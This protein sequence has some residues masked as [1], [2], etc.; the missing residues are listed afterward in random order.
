MTIEVNK[1]VKAGL[2]KKVA[3]PDDGRRV[4]LTVTKMAQAKLNALAPTQCPVNDAIFA[5]LDSKDFRTFAKIIGSLVAGTE[6]ALALLHLLA[7]QR[8]RQA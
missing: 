4:I 8:R 5:S 3:H 1:L 6:E 2:V 7:E